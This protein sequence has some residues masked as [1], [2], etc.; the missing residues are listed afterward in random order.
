MSDCDRCGVC[1]EACPEVFRMNEAGYIQV[2][3]LAQYPED[4]V[5]EAI[6]HCPEKCI[7]WSES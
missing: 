3:D 1:I 7:F 2:T 6:K 4:C 5:E